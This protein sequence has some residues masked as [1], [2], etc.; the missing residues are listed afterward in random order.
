MVKEQEVQQ[1]QVEEVLDVHQD[2]LL[3][4][5]V[6]GAVAQRNNLKQKKLVKPL[7]YISI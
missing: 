5:Q 6:V 4:G 3:L 2:D 1:P 7:L